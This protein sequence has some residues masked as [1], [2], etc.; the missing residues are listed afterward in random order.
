MRTPFLPSPSNRLFAVKDPESVA[1]GV[2][3]MRS[4]VLMRMQSLERG[5]GILS[6]RLKR[7][8]PSERE[9]NKPR[10]ESGSKRGRILAPRIFTALALFLFDTYSRTQNCTACRQERYDTYRQAN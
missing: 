3:G 10:K 8:K 5:E 1:M 4:P 6:R 2:S 7:E 9:P